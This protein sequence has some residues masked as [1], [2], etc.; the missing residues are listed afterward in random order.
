MKVAHITSVSFHCQIPKTLI[1]TTPPGVSGDSPPGRSGIDRYRFG[2]ICPRCP[3][4]GGWWVSATA[5][6]RLQ[7]GCCPA[8]GMERFHLAETFTIA[9]SR[10]TPGRS[11]SSPGAGGVSAYGE[12]G[13]TARGGRLSVS[14]ETSRCRIPVH[15][16]DETYANA[17]LNAGVVARQGLN[18]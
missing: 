2:V 15:Q 11:A 1:T 14:A 5:T 16:T 3:R 12:R 4:G 13:P 9:R 6:E 17:L 10:S 8:D 18:L 7:A